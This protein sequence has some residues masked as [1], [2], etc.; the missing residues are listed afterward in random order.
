MFDCEFTFFVLFTGGEIIRSDWVEQAT[1]DHILAALMPENRLALEVSMYTGLRIDDVLHLRTEQVRQGR[2][3]VKEMKTGK[4]KRIRLPNAL[5]DEILSHAGRFYAFE[6]RLDQKKPRTRQAVFKDLK[7]AQELFRVRGVHLS[8]H[9]ARKI[10]SV[11]AF[12][13]TCSVSKVQSL[14]NHSSEAVTMLYAMADELTARRLGV[15][16]VYVP[17]LR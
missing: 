14:L 9:T 11:T 12:K 5:R 15:R 10:Y 1:F 2:F 4:R 13:L 17:T 3:T 7:R 6:G 8:P 16:P